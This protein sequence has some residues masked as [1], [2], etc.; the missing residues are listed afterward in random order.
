MNKIM[1]KV[2]LLSSIAVIIVAILYSFNKANDDT[3]REE[4][5]YNG[6][7]IDNISVGSAFNV[8]VI[9]TSNPSDNRIEIRLKDE[10]YKYLKTTLYNGQLNVYLD[11]VPNKLSKILDDYYLDIYTTHFSSIRGSGATDF[12]VEKGFEYTNL[13]LQFSEASD[14][15]AEDTIDVLGGVKIICSGASDVSFNG[16]NIQGEFFASLSDASKL[17]IDLGK[18]NADKNYISCSGSSKYDA[19]SFVLKN[20][21]VKLSGA[22]SAVINVLDSIEASVTTAASLRYKKNINTQLYGASKNIRAF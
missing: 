12:N 13:S 22:S 15:T 11:D 16:L 20:L 7:K 2:F 9:K 5:Y 8:R 6:E 10:A 17:K 1:K 14:F 21:N 18:V 4:I 3:L 19:P